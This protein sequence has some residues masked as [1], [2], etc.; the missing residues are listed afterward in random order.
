MELSVKKCFALK[1]LLPILLLV[2]VTF[3]SCNKPQEDGILI[4]IKNNTNAD[5]LFSST[6]QI[7]FGSIDAG[8]V[9][10]YKTF[11]KVI[12]YPGARI[13]IAADTFY[14]GMLYCGTPPLPYLE[15]GKY[16]LDI[17]T[18]TAINGFNAI[19]IRE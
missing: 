17:A 6:A 12:A 7:S 4:R 15:K 11:K 9:T 10:A 19:N 18:D 16:R 14:A 8:A 5:F 1:I 2:F 13:V 3:I